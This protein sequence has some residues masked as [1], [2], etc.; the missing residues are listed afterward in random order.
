M[1]ALGFALK[2]EQSPQREEQL[3]IEGS[4]QSSSAGEACGGDAVKKART[5]HAVRAVGT[6]DRRNPQVRNRRGVPAIDP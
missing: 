2:A 5:P 6:T 4:T 1:R 3:R